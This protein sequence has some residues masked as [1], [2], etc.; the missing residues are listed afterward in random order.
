MAEKMFKLKENQ[1][2]WDSFFDDGME[3]WDLE[4]KERLDNI[5]WT[6]EEKE[7]YSQK[8]YGDIS[9]EKI[10]PYWYES[11][12]RRSCLQQYKPVILEFEEFANKSFDEITADDIKKFSIITNKKNK[13]NHLNTFLLNRVKSGTINNKNVEFLI[14]LLPDIYKELGKII[15]ENGK[16]C[17]DERIH[18]S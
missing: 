1:R 3:E 10:T 4:N 16:E 9:A 8:T 6:D 15:A 11:K 18:C 7:M 12:K 5:I 2:V 14:S 13:L 17:C